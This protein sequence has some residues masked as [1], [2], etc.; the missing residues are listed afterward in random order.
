ADAGSQR[1]AGRE[2]AGAAGKSAQSD[3]RDPRTN[4]DGKAIDSKGG[5]PPETPVVLPPGGMRV[6]TIFPPGR[7]GGRKGV[8][9]EPVSSQPADKTGQGSPGKA[10]ADPKTSGARPGAREVPVDKQGPIEANADRFAGLPVVQGPALPWLG[11]RIADARSPQ[12]PESGSRGPGRP[13]ARG[14]P[15][16][17]LDGQV[18]GARAQESRAAAAQSSDKASPA[19]PSL[20]EKAGTSELA[21]PGEEAQPVRLFRLPD[22]LITGPASKP[23]FRRAGQDSAA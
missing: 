20:D 19:G 23:K 9:P 13:D 8:Q 18:G 3:S 14:P 6:G 15:P 5:R 7:E 16:T 2:P 17:D 21:A 22:L 1:A 11:V 4:K 12:P 10:G